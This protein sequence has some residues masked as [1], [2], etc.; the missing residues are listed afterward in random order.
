MRAQALST[1]RTLA[2]VR[3]RQ[4]QQA[5]N[6]TINRELAALKRMFRLGEKAGRVVRRPYIAMLQ[7]RNARIGFFERSEFDAVLAHLP[8]DLRAVFEVTY[9]LGWRVKSEILT[10]QWA[11]VDFRSGWLRLEPGETKN[12]EGRQFPLTPDLRAVLER[13]RE[14]TIAGEQT[15]GAVIPW[16]FHRAGMRIKSFR[17]AWVTACKKAG[18]PER[19][20]HDFRRTAVR[21]L[22]RA[23]VPR[24]TAMKMVGH[25][26]ESIYRRYAIVDEAMLKEGAGSCKSST[27]PSRVRPPMLFDWLTRSVSGRVPVESRAQSEKRSALRDEVSG[28]SLAG[29]SWWAGRD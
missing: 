20:P 4:E 11:H 10:R 21:N 12:D 9:I 5:A 13:Q 15:T 28:R 3:H 26:T 1:E 6:A 14:R 2:Y 18:I 25:R 19:V 8:V 16:V 23:G 24:S 27:T 17:R 22:E 7:E 29:K